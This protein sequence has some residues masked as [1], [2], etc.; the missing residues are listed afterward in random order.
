MTQRKL[1]NKQ[2]IWLFTG[3]AL[4]A[5]LAFVWHARWAANVGGERFAQISVDR[6]VVLS[7]PSTRQHTIFESGGVQV[8]FSP[9]AGAARFMRS[10]CPDQICVQAG[11]LSLP[12]QMA[13]CVPNRT[14][15]LIVGERRPQND[16]PDTFAY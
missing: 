15:L 10:D 9:S 13:V 6:Q 12:G 16:A 11:W 14:A 8:A 3:L 4:L 7:V 2:D 1:F 5:L